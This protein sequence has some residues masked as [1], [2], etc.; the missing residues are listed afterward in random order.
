MTDE[1][2]AIEVILPLNPLPVELYDQEAMA[3]F[4]NELAQNIPEFLKRG[5]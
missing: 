3:I 1:T 5:Q 2:D 4:L